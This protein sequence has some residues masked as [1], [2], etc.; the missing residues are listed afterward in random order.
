MRALQ[1]SATVQKARVL[2]V[3][4][5]PFH[6]S[7]SR[8]VNDIRRVVFRRPK[9]G[10][11]TEARTSQWDCDLAQWQSDAQQAIGAGSTPVFT[12]NVKRKDAPRYAVENG[13]RPESTDN[14]AVG[15][16]AS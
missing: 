15:S 13:L 5:R 12:T 14:P 10:E 6:R 3:S 11:A 16:A 7:S 9:G 8:Q 4:Q 1:A 2:V